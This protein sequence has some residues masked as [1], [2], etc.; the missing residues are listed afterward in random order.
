MEGNPLAP[1]E[2]ADPPAQVPTPGPADHL[3]EDAK[4][5]FAQIPTDGKAISNKAVRVALGWEA[6]ETSDRYFSV[7]DRLEDAGLVIRGRGRG[8]TVRRA[9]E[10]ADPEAQP[11]AAIESDSPEEVADSLRREHELY[12]PLHE[13]IKSEWA[14]V[15]RAS[16]I[17]VEITAHQGRRATGI[18]ARPDIVSVEVRAFDHVPGKY[19]EIRTFE[20]KPCDAINVQAV[21]EA[22]AHRRAAT[23]SYVL[24]HVPPDRQSDLET[25]VV[26]LCEVARGHGIGVITVETPDDYETWDE[27]EVA[28]RTMPD[29]EYLDAFIGSQLSDSAQ[30]RIRLALR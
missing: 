28:V 16:P 23:H 22:L 2:G 17:A 14:R 7:R 15:N 8:G 5:L 18:W 24:L 26:E 27:R 3:G 11:P 25:A 30:G 4:A 1:L 20:V 19:L 9:V 6:E 29:P 12:E 10:E 21:Y 13:V